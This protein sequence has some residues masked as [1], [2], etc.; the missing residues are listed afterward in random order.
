M[1]E[2]D[3]DGTC[4]LVLGL[5]SSGEAAARALAE[6]GAHVSVLDGS[7]AP[8]ALERAARLHGLGMEVELGVD[9]DDVV[10]LEGIDLVVTSP[11]V[12]PVRGILA[13][14]VDRDVPVWSE[15]EL[16]WR[17]SADRSRLVGVTG[18]NGKTSTTELIAAALAAPA[19]GNIGRPLVELLTEQPPPPLAVAELS[20]FQLHFA[21]S[22]RPQV[23]VLLNIAPDHLDWHGDLR[24]YGDDK[25]RLWRAQG[26]DD[27]LVANADDDGACALVDRHPPRGRLVRFTL[28]APDAG[29]V[30]V[31][32]GAI[33]ARLDGRDVRLV[34]IDELA[35]TGPHDIANACAAVAAA[36]S[37]GADAQAVSAAL[38]AFRPGPHRLEHVAVVDEVVYVNDSKATNP[39]AAAAA[40]AA[41]PSV[42][43][44]AGG[45]AKGLDFAPLR[46]VLVG[47]VRAA[48]TIGTSGPDIARLCRELGI[49]V[50][51][52]GTLDRAV[53]E[54][55][56]VARAGDTV[57]LAPACASMDQFTDYAERGGVFRDAVA[58][59]RSSTPTPPA[60][61]PAATPP[62]EI[63][64][65]PEIP[66]TPETLGRSTNER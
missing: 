32:D 47:R 63:P 17:L 61:P 14:A 9:L 16:A 54:A 53:V 36:L 20:S 51:E 2:V 45:L 3:L 38:R 49:D 33:H 1:T 11:G 22:L 50:V 37:A 27:V 12:P 24:S 65:I 25:A 48:V 66:E 40:L 10:S 5:G 43:W 42:V 44:I 34:G 4:A 23:A 18:T 60:G 41:H 35:R 7:Q 52:A 30:G 8:A 57:L 31:A 58:L 59:L 6:A 56:R 26:A 28:S 62:S 46:D 21:E 13:A 64:E 15:P 19:A 39:H 55:A 29:E